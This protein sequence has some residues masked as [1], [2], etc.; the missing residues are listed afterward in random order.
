MS[1]ADRDD[2]TYRQ[3]M[4]YAAELKELYQRNRT[5]AAG[6]HA[7]HEAR[8]RIQ[9]VLDTNLITPVFQPIANLRTGGVAGVEAL[10]RF[11]VEPV[12]SPEAW[13]S[14]AESCGLHAE[15]DL[16]AAAA[17]L[18]VMPR[19]PERA[20]LSINM[21]P[22]TAVSERFIDAIK[23]VDSDRLIIEITEHD[24]VHDYAVLAS[25][26]ARFRADGGRVAVDDAGAGFAS[27]R[28]TLAID[29]D[30]IKLDI[31]LVRDIDSDRARR[32]L[33][34]A[35][36]SF[37]EEM[38]AAIVAEGIETD[39]EIDVLRDLGVHF[40]QGYRLARPAPLDELELIT[41]PI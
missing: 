9:T 17:A 35:L 31:T 27:L 30:I 24:A 40:G 5:S 25:S 22:A 21:A 36:I 16:A 3:A 26:L 6:L 33:A 18:E 41:L 1:A 8:D 20:F 10:A 12:R 29:P 37:A 7:A 14:D 34:R 13:F 15:L 2:L 23:G 28:H 39:A 32:A 11:R 4:V 38:D 19:L